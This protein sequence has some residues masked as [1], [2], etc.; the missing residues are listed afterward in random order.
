MDALVPDA[1]A[2]PGHTLLQDLAR[3]PFETRRWT[4]TEVV[5]ALEKNHKGK[6]VLSGHDLI[7]PEMLHKLIDS[8]IFITVAAELYNG[9]WLKVFSLV[10]DVWKPGDIRT[11]LKSAEKGPKEVFSYRPI[12]LLPLLG[13]TLE[14]LMRLRLQPIGMDQRFASP[15]QFGFRQ[16]NSTIEA[17]ST[18]RSVINPV[19][20]THL[21]TP[22]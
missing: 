22:M 2:P 4:C 17:T 11:L 5:R 16:G 21:S 13:K 12:C 3:L 14:R 9:C 10:P 1:G 6:E 20:Y 18:V 15:R 8:D 7:E 19:S